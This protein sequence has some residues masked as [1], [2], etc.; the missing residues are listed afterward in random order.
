[1]KASCSDSRQQATLSLWRRRGSGA[2]IPPHLHPCATHSLGNDTVGIIL[3]FPHV[4]P[5]AR[6][7]FI[8]TEAGP[9]ECRSDPV[10]ARGNFDKGFCQNVRMGDWSGV[11]TSSRRP[12]DPAANGAFFLYNMA[13]DQA[14]KNNVAAANPDIQA[15][16]LM[17][18]HNEHRPTYDQ[19]DD[20]DNNDFCPLTIRCRPVRTSR[21]L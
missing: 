16:I 5:Q 20:D 6:P 9:N 17:I 14:Q 3:H 11:C 19:G 4:V 10:L 7:K 21:V 2:K 13:Q 12:C 8:Y 18:M 1:M 15:E